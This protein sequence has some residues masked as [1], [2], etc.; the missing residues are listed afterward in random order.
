[1]NSGK[2]IIMMTAPYTLY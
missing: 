2:D 1:V